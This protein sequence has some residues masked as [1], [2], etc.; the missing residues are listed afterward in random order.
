MNSNPHLIK[1]LA[2]AALAFGTLTI[3]SGG[4]ALFGSAEAQAALGNVV[5]F[6]LWFNFT[7]GFFYVIAGAGLLGAKPWAATLAVLLAA[8]TVIVSLAMAVYA[9]TGGAFEMRT[10]GAL[11]I[12]SV[13]WITIAF[14]AMR[15]VKPGSATV[16]P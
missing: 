2:I 7:A 5:P 4:R 8:A 6:V 16:N 12:R 3:F 13:F 15:A 1:W 14:V 10:V 9:T 11:A